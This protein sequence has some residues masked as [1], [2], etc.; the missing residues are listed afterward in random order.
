LNILNGMTLLTPDVVGALD[1]IAWEIRELHGERGHNVDAAL[2]RDPAF[3]RNRR[4]RSSL[5]RSLIEE[6]FTVGA[7]KA[8]LT[9][10]TGPG[11]YLQIHVD[12]SASFAT[13]RLRKAERTRNNYKV[14]ANKN[15]SW[16]ESV[17]EA[18]IPEQ[19]FVIGFVLDDNGLGDIFVAEV[20][21]STAGN[22]GD[23]IL[24]NPLLLGERGDTP[25]GFRTDHDDTLPGIDDGT[26]DQQLEA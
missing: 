22:P 16:S 5:G 12:L 21:G 15:S 1:T 4:P 3:V 25:A 2:E 8:G 10:T 20:L 18:L 17:D 14:L 26:D 13:I 23:L 9:A 7:A 19:R 24:G 6:G 11:G